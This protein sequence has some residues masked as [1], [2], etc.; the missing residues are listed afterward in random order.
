[1]ITHTHIYIHK[2]S[3]ACSFLLKLPR[4]SSHLAHPTIRCSWITATQCNITAHITRTTNL[5]NLLLIRM[6]MVWVIMMM[7]MGRWWWWM[8]FHNSI[9][10]LLNLMMV[11]MMMLMMK[12]R[13]RLLLILLLFLQ[14]ILLTLTFTTSY[15]FGGQSLVTKGCPWTK[16]LTPLTPLYFKSRRCH[17][18]YIHV[19]YGT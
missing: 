1:M 19:T 2:M 15:T 11:W 18:L 13:R 9:I 8:L 17:D 16:V 5:S 3:V 12:R 7:K 14:G 6:V 4:A 10:K